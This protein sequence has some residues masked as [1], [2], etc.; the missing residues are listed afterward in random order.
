MMTTGLG[1][2]ELDSVAGDVADATSNAAKHELVRTEILQLVAASR[3]G[4]RLP[5]ERTL[6]TTF[7]VSRVTVRQAVASLA[8][9]GYVSRLQGAGTFVADPKISKGAQLTSFSEDMASRGMVASSRVLRAEIRPAGGE[10]GTRLGLSPS[11]AVHHIERVR[12]ADRVPMC[13]EL[14][15]VP[16][17]VAPGLSDQDLE[18]SIYHVL[19][20]H[21]GVS[22]T[23]ADQ[24]ISPTVLD[25]RQAHLLQVPEFSAALMV[26]RVGYDKRGTAVEHA[27]SIYRGDRYD[28]QMT[29]RRVQA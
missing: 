28:I 15:D 27:V 29:V 13:L 3:V 11:D 1:V 2:E 24:V 25:K 5:P 7:G 4:D 17:A 6:A 26:R 22:I 9:A 21:N 8:L 14:I 23:Q 18:G 12:L 10:L 20:A 16:V 19:E